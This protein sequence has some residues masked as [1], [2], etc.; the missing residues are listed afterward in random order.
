MSQHD[1]DL[2]LP[3]RR[4]PWSVRSQLLLGGYSNQFG[5][6]FFGFG[7]ILMWVFGFKADLSA[8]LFALG[9]VETAPGVVTA[10]E[11][12]NAS[13][14][15]RLIYAYTYSF[16]VERLEK[17]YQ[18]V[19]YTTGH[20]FGPEQEVVVEYLADYPTLSRLEGAR[21]AYFS[22]WAFC[23]VSIIPL[24]GLGLI[25]FGLR[26]GVKA[27]VLL[28]KGKIGRGVLKSK[29]ATNVEVNECPV[30]K[31]T[32]EFTADDGRCY[33]VVTKTHQ[34]ERLQDDAE[35]RL[36][37][38]PTNPADAVLLD[39]LP[40]APDIDE[41]GQIRPLSLRSGLRVLIVPVVAILINVL[42]LIYGDIH[43]SA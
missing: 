24:M 23:F 32:F 43:V 19:S 11:Q 35:E 18:G 2:A 6:V 17:Q 41:R 36:L 1:Y 16:R 28:A 25:A 14:N 29:R 27:S 40:G 21:R 8:V 4:V 12:T 33:E 13:E 15:D 31:L 20:E 42:V 39:N 3:P 9:R 22:P 38:H 5:W 30:Y 7:M 10:V 26:N 37:Y 34:V